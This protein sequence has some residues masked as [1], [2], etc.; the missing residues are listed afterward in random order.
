MAAIEA[1]K[2]ENID[3]RRPRGRPRAAEMSS[4]IN[5]SVPESLAAK[6]L[7]LQ[8]Y[9]HAPSMTEV[10][11]NALVLYAAAVAEHKR[12]GSIYFKRDADGKERELALFI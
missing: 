6:L 7:E 5:I 3:S 11:R 4:R 2:V 8:E 9:T 12:G 1:S 10:V